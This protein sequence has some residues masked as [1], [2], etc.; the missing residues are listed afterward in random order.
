MGESR[1]GF[2]LEIIKK[3]KLKKNWMKK[4]QKLLMMMISNILY[5]NSMLLL[6][7]RTQNHKTKWDLAH[8]FHI[9]FDLSQVTSMEKNVDQLL[10]S[11]V[12]KYLA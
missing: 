8:C 4:K 5:T 7:R 1:S 10:F 12:Q 2:D 6:V 11:N 3:S 9:L